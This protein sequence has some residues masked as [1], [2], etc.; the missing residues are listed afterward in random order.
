MNLDVRLERTRRATNVCVL[1]HFGAIQVPEGGRLYASVPHMD[2]ARR[3]GRRRISGVACP[4][5]A[6]GRGLRAVNCSDHS[7]RAALPTFDAE[8]R[9]RQGRLP[10]LR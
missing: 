6:L 4:I 1:G 10:R 5:A 2:G 8:I 3:A 9:P 7:R